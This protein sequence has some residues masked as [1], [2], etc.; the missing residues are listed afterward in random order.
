MLWIM[1]HETV[2]DCEQIMLRVRLINFVSGGRIFS[3][4]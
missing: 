3:V 4:S 2:T 1:R